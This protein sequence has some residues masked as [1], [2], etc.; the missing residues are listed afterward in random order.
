MCCRIFLKVSVGYAYE[1]FRTIRSDL[2]YGIAYLFV[3]VALA[4][5]TLIVQAQQ[6]VRI[7][8]RMTV[9]L[10]GRLRLI[11]DQRLLGSEDTHIIDHEVI[12]VEVRCHIINTHAE[13]GIITTSIIMQNREIDLIPVVRR[14]YIARHIRGDILP[15][16]SIG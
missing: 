3:I 14:R 2:P 15:C 16:I 6:N 7:F 12:T 1:T 5:D 11:S 13:I 4:G 10:T 9:I 8:L